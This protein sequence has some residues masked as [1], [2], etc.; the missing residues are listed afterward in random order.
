MIYMILGTADKRG[1]TQI[2]NTDPSF[3][4]SALIGVYL[5]FPFLALLLGRHFNHAYA[6]FAAD[7]DLLGRVLIFAVLALAHR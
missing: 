3:L 4:L 2:K 7:V 1:L 6:V 5:R